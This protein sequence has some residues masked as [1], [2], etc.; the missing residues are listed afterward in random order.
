MSKAAEKETTLTENANKAA[1]Y[2]VANVK[3]ENG[4]ELFRK[5]FN[6]YIRDKK[7]GQESEVLNII[8][9]R[10][11]IKDVIGESI[12]SAGKPFGK[13]TLED[14]SGKYEFTFWSED[15]LRFKNL[16]AIGVNRVTARLSGINVTWMSL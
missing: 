10:E 14:Y 12:G 9:P 13:M 8:S 2:I 16:F 15:Y 3:V 7:T 4:R 6:V 11:E 5:G 1:E